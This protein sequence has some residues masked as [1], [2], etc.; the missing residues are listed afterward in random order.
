[1]GAVVVG[2][3]V[4]MI[5]SRVIAVKEYLD[6]RFTDIFVGFKLSDNDRNR[7]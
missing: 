4:G 7:K 5:V 1:M 6:E 3:I 2:T